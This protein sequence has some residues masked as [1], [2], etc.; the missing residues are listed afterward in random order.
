MQTDRRDVKQK[1]S[2]HK[3]EHSLGSNIFQPKVYSWKPSWY[4]GGAF[5]RKHFVAGAGNGV[6]S[7]DFVARGGGSGGVRSPPP[8]SPPPCSKNKEFVLMLHGNAT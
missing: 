1:T 6:R 8:C 2:F 3:I 4:F 7:A 5:K